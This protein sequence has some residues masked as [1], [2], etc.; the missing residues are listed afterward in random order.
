MGEH[1][2]QERFTRHCTDAAF[3]YATAAT[4]AYAAF[5]DQVLSFWSQA[6][7]PSRREPEQKAF[8]WGWPVPAAQPAPVPVWNP[9]AWA[10]PQSFAMQPFAFGFPAAQANPFVAWF[11]MF[12][13]ATMPASWP[14]ANMFIASGVPR[15]VAWPAA[16]AN[17]AAM[18]AVDV[19]TNSV[20]NAFA[21]YRT[22]SGHATAQQAWPAAHLM[23]LAVLAPLTLGASMLSNGR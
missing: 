2:L 6:L 8:P 10:T 4:A 5:A 15:S 17:V 7:Q 22:D 11:N 20:R 13:F 19:A 14:M 1:H 18:E 9:W 12:P 23:M 3:G 16:E 21:S